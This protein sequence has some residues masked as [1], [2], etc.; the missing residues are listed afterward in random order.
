MPDIR[1]RQQNDPL[2]IQLTRGETPV[3]DITLTAK[4]G[5]ILTRMAPSRSIDRAAVGSA[6]LVITATLA[7]SGT[8]QG[9]GVGTLTD[10]QALAAAG[11]KQA[12]GTGAITD[13]QTLT[14][15]GYKTGLG[16][17]EIVDTAVLVA[18]GAGTHPVVVPATHAGLLMH[19]RA[20]F[21]GYHATPRMPLIYRTGSVQMRVAYSMEATGF[22]ANDDDEAMTLLM[23]E[24]A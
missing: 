3:R 21:V 15:N 24:A 4:D 14:A 18:T 6:S 19:D 16:T 20:Q 1:L 22:G 7:V 10:T 2:S 11:Y 12:A 13:A 9:L 5:V 23:L 8:K 17:G